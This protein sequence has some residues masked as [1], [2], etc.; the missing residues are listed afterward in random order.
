MVA[1]AG[2]DLGPDSAEQSSELAVAEQNNLKL[3]YS[4]LIIRWMQPVDISDMMSIESVS[5]GKH[6]WTPESFR[7]ELKNYVA[8]YQVL[9]APDQPIALLG[10][11]GAWII[12]DECHI[13]T[14]AVRPEYRGFALGELQVCS[15]LEKCYRQKVR[16]V[17][18]EVR[19]SNTAAH[20]LY[21]KYGF[22]LMGLRPK[23]YQDTEEDAM[24]MT[25]PDIQSDPYHVLYEARKHKLIGRIKC[26]PE[27]FGI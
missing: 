14:V 26:L 11:A 12:E 5:F 23:Y 21:Y 17:T 24:I 4:Q 6:H 1:S 27:G 15:I 20:H 7:N 19:T 9:I 3:D 22:N 18:L 2:S 10:Y 13:T 8:Q 16:W 25:T